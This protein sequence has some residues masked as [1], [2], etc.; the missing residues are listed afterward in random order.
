MVN[1][2]VETLREY[3]KTIQIINNNPTAHDYSQKVALA[4]EKFKTRLIRIISNPK[5]DEN[6]QE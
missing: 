2:V 3:N 1:S 4:E 6:T 5:A